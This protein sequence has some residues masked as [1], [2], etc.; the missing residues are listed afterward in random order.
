MSYQGITL[1]SVT[2]GVDDCTEFVSNSPSK[3]I[4]GYQKP[5]NNIS[6]N[7][8]LPEGYASVISHIGAVKVLQLSK[9]G[10]SVG[11]GITSLLHH[12]FIAVSGLGVADSVGV[13]RLESRSRSESWSWLL[14]HR[15]IDTVAV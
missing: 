1:S 5:C 3:I 4:V 9:N 12:I 2:L 15:R 14:H 10:R 8:L 7:M 6:I 13:G 11:H